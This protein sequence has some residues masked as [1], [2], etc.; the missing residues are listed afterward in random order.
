MLK[1]NVHHNKHLQHAWNRYGEEAFNFLI[2]EKIEGTSKE[3]LQHEQTWLDLHRMN[4][5]VY[6]LVF[7]V[8]NTTLGYKYTEEQRQEICNRL[9]KYHPTRGKHFSEEAK[10]NMKKK[11]GKEHPSYGKKRS[12]EYCKRLSE[13]L[14]GRIFSEEHCRNISRAK[15]GKKTGRKMTAGHKKMLVTIS[16]K[17]YPSFYNTVTGEVIPPGRNLAQ[18]CRDFDLDRRSMGA[19]QKGKYKQHR[20]WVLKD[21]V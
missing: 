20:G 13:I 5:E 10:Q 7:H 14:T 11:R 3:V 18:L 21:G 4:G 9:A 19:V 1:R 6:N 15:K 8:T 2:L 17:P 16:S 12:K